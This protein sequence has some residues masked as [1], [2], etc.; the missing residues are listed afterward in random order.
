MNL[1]FMK[2]VLIFFIFI[3]ICFSDDTNVSMQLSWFDQFQFAGYYMAKEKGFYKNA[4]LNVDIKP[5]K[6]GMDIPSEVS[7]GNLDFAVGRETLIL[8]KANKKEIVALY[9]LFQAS[10]LVLISTKESGINKIAD[11]KNKKIMLAIDDISEASIQSM[12]I[13]QRLDLEKLNLIKHSYN[14]NDLLNKNVDVISAYSSKVP[15]HL[16]KMN[17]KYNTFAPR[18]YGFDMYSDLLYTSESK[19]K[20]DLET[21]VKFKEASLK[22]WDYAYSHINETVDLI[23]KKYNTQNLTKDELIFEAKELK[24][25]SYY[26]TEKLGS[27][28]LNKLRR[29]YD[30]YNIMGLIKNQIDIKD[31]VFLENGFHVFLRNTFETLCNYIKLPYIYFSMTIFFFLIWLLIYKQIEVHKT[32]K[33]LL[34][35][36]KELLR[37]NKELKNL[38]E[39][40]H[41]TKLYNRRYFEFIAKEHLSL[42]KRENKDMAVLLIDIDNFKKVNDTYGHAVG[43]I[44]LISMA[45]M[46]TSHKRESDV[47]A[48]YGGEEFIILLPNTSLE[49]ARIYAE[50]LRKKIEKQAIYVEDLTLYITVSM[51]L[52]IFKNQDNISSVFNRADE[53]LYISKRNGKNQLN[54]R[55]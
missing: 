24:K 48:R 21:V 22:G 46:M 38:S 20:N 10:P 53:S 41:L 18:N 39:E 40:D 35:K 2:L 43:D 15:Y 32:A 3:D 25:L 47:L 33:K 17:I 4:G 26:Q 55:I 27:L 36:E 23:L 14:L 28:D 12:I 51:G 31:F 13:S 16:E 45:Q 50:S 11:F 52:T 29:T 37:V 1:Y 9:A 19:I 30:L 34:S 7:K 42:A 5:F 8:E 54:F 44:T 49:G 6:L